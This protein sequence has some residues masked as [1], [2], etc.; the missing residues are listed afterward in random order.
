[1]RTPHP[2]QGMAQDGTFVAAGAA[3]ERALR[4]DDGDLGRPRKTVLVL[5][6]GGMRGFCHIGIVRAIERL[7]LQVD[8][9][10]GTSMGAVM[11]A[12]Y[13]A[14][15]ESRQ[16]EVAAGEISLK[17][18][19]RLNLLKFLV[20]GYRHASV[21]KG[22]TF[23]ELLRKW[24]PY[25]SF[26]ELQ[27]PFFCNAM[28][29]TTGASRF[30]GLPGSDTMPVADAVYASACLPTIFEPM[31]I[32]GD[33]YVDGGMTETL[34]L[35]IARARRADLVIG[36]DLSHRDLHTKVPYKASLPHILFQTY[37][38]MGQALNEHN[39]H[40][41]ADD[42]T[43]IIKPKVS[44]LGLLDM[45]DVQEIVRLGEREALEVLTT[46][47]LTR[48]LCR[49]E[50]VAEEDRM[51]QRPRDHVHLDVDMNA[52][53]HC[54]ICA[55]TCVTQGYAAVPLGD[56]VRKLHNYECTRDMACERNCP[57]GAIRLQNI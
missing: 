51:V 33:H 6:G 21:Y 17:D 8:E 15:L 40:R 54:G 39:L 28:S 14:G 23:H 37:E 7:G 44:H 19:F 10:V 45:P 36:V 18:Y 2:H 56:V 22:R 35:R 29:L 31:G 3:M 1:M 11:G 13:A 24:L 41:Y 12:L 25:A 4:G 49:P 30:F 53:I 27:R 26:E 46:H 52:C 9:V 43:I 34:A 55:A 42:R 57:T 47:P 20:R 16:I 38:V 32:E 5:G 48:Y 50:V